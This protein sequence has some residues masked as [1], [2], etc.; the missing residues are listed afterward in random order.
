MRGK[1]AIPEL[2]LEIE[3]FG[4]S[5][6]SRRRI[7]A[8]PTGSDGPLRAPWPRAAAASAGAGASA[9]PSSSDTPRVSEVEESRP[10]E[11]APGRAAGY[12]RPVRR[13]GGVGTLIFLCIGVGLLCGSL[14]AL[15]STWSFFDTTKSVDGVIA[16]VGEIRDARGKP[17]STAV[18]E[19]TG[20][21]GQ[22]HRDRTSASG[23]LM[24]HVGE[25]VKL[26]YDPARP[27]VAVGENRGTRWFVGV[28]LGILGLG[29][30]GIAARV[31]IKAWRAT[32]A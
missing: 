27:G 29:F 30:A 11:I 6:S 8:R 21:D 13:I 14:V 32:A 7:A 5:T 17:V 18:V 3:S 22:K 2:E 16:E 10:A 25:T 4:N 31:A 20:P 9:F 15:R 1:Q 24:F 12:S 28:G 26:R 19:W 23:S